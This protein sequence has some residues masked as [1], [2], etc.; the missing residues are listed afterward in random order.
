VVNDT[1]PDW[2]L[3]SK[4]KK[5]G[6]VPR[7][8]VELKEI[9]VTITLPTTPTTTTPPTITPTITQTSTTSTDPKI[10]EKKT[11]RSK[12]SISPQPSV[13]TI[14][15]RVKISAKKLT[16]E[17]DI[18]TNPTPIN[19]QTPSDGAEDEEVGQIESNYYKPRTNTLQLSPE[20]SVIKNPRTS[21]LKEDEEK[22]TSEQNKKNPSPGV[23]TSF[24]DE[25]KTLNSARGKPNNDNRKS[26]APNMLSFLPSNSKY[27]PN[28]NIK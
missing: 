8:Y 16:T 25:G 7:T 18:L 3:V 17:S 12:T 15:K 5:K 22:E 28:S 19:P 14:K 26:K 2:I 1:N 4:D 10:I 6:Y 9:T 11:L 24:K 21:A 13:S 27:V 23:G 20:S